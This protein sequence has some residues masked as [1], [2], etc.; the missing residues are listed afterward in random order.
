VTIP[1]AA[2]ALGISV[3]TAYERAKTG[4]L[5]SGVPVVTVGRRRVVPTLALHTALTL[6][7]PIPLPEPRPHAD[8]LADLLAKIGPALIEYAER[9]REGER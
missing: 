3:S 9:V 6:P 8:A 1:E 5:C 7:A 2:R 4:E